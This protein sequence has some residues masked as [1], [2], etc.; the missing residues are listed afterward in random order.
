MS[1]SDE[2]ARRRLRVEPDIPLDFSG[3]P[4]V[5]E[6]IVENNRQTKLKRRLK[7]SEFINEVFTK[8]GDRAIADSALCCVL[9]DF[10]QECVEKHQVF[11]RSSALA[12]VLYLWTEKGLLE[13]GQKLLQ[14][15]LQ[16]EL[17]LHKNI[18]D[19]K[20]ATVSL[21]L[22]TR[23]TNVDLDLTGKIIAM[24]PA[25]TH[26]RRLFFP[27]FE[28]AARTGNTELAFDTLRLGRSKDVEFWDVDY[29]ELLCCLQKANAEGGPTT[30]L[31]DEML[32]CMAD[33]HPVVGKGNGEALRHL[34]GGEMTQVHSSTGVCNWCGTKLHTF[35]FSPS[36]RATLLN[37]IE[38][39]LIAP[40]VEGASR[41]EP[42]KV[43]TPKEK[44]RRW[45][46]FEAF[47]ER[48]SAN[49]YDAVIDGA[50]VGYYGLSSWYREAKEASLR[51]RGVDPVTVPEYEL[52]EVPMP[53]DVPPKFS[54]IDEMLTQTRR[55]GKKPLVMLHNRH[56][57]SPSTD[58]AEWLSRWKKDASL[59]ACP[60]FMNDD[61][62]WLYA[63]IR[64][65]NCLVVS[66]DQM[67]DHHFLLLS[68]R[69]FLR[70]RQRHRVTYK[71]LFQRVTGGVTLVVMPPRPYAVWV[72]R[73]CLSPLHWHVPVL[74][75][76]DIINQATNHGT[77]GEVEVDKDGDDL[78]DAWLCTAAKNLV[79]R[80]V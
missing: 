23:T 68:H 8:L 62:C 76:V 49:E 32:E 67:R 21:R 50:N 27:L 17:L 48:L 36:D 43:V 3:L 7:V 30:L 18:L 5:Q 63:A 51:A 77:E 39:K 52:C 2:P 41:Y 14:Q 66:N 44:E 25:G 26:K 74:T 64:K 24:L 45:Q 69:S 54:L 28:H 15:V 20:V 47:K 37:D 31:L 33:H 75:T 35:D 12:K 65:P 34:L 22:L 4:A 71:A 57:E 29:R 6:M 59:I 42:D 1:E 38:T 13:E 53:V 55:L 61:Y 78:C 72:Q 79:N 19:E 11:P 10:L 73:G 56:L 60:G 40:R 58:N 80:S 16:A 70:W 9:S 46:E